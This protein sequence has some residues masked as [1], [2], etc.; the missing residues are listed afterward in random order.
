[1]SKKYTNE[2]NIDTTTS[3]N[4]NNNLVYN[5]NFANVLNEPTRIVS[6]CQLRGDFDVQTNYNLLNKSPSNW[7]KLTL[8]AE[9]YSNYRTT[10]DQPL[11]YTALGSNSSDG[12][13]L[14]NGTGNTSGKLRI[15]RSGSTIA[16]YRH[17]LETWVPIYVGRANMSDTNIVLQFETHLGPAQQPI[18]I[19]FDNHLINKGHIVNCQIK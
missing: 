13:I 17:S 16:E 4:N 18:K 11:N 8:N 19:A 6:L 15:I 5:A 1:L 14:L 10:S 7:A 3:N 9:Q 2:T 12:G